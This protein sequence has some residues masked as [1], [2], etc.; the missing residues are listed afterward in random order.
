MTIIDLS[1]L[2]AFISERDKLDVISITS[3]GLMKFWRYGMCNLI[4]FPS[5]WQFSIKINQTNELKY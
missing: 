1:S 3:V 2:G 4:D 5:S